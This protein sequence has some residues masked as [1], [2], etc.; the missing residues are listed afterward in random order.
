MNPWFTD[1]EK[2]LNRNELTATSEQK[3]DIYDLLDWLNCAHHS[4]ST[5]ETG[6]E[7]PEY[8]VELNSITRV[9]LSIFKLELSNNRPQLLNKLTKDLFK[10]SIQQ[11]ILR[12]ESIFTDQTSFD[13]LPTLVQNWMLRTGDTSELPWRQLSDFSQRDLRGAQFSS[14]EEVKY[15]FNQSNLSG[16]AFLSFNAQAVNFIDTTIRHA[17][18]R[19]SSMPNAKFTNADLSYT[20]L[21]TI[22]IE[23]ADCC[24]AIFHGTR[25][26]DANLSNANLSHAKLTNVDL[27]YA[28]FKNARLDDAE[29]SIHLS[30][31]SEH[32]FDR[33]INHL[34][35]DGHGVL[36]SIDSIP[37]EYI[38]L[39][40]AAM[41]MVIEQ[42]NKLP[43]EK[44][45]GS[46]TSLADV[47]LRN[48][49]YAED[50]TIAGF[51]DKRLLPRWMEN[52][53][54]ALLNP[55]E[56]D[57]SFVLE[58]LNRALTLDWAAPK[59]Q[60]AVN[61]LL[62]AATQ[63]PDEVEQQLLAN[64]LRQRLLADPILQTALPAIE[65]IEPGLS[66]E[67]YLF[68]AEDGLRV[69]ALESDQ[70]Q[71]LV[72]STSTQVSLQ[73]LYQFERHSSASA[74]DNVAPTD[75]DQTYA[76]SPFLKAQYLSIIGGQVARQLV[77]TVLASS[78]HAQ[79]FIEA[80]QC[81]RVS[82]KLLS[83]L[84]QRELAE[85]FSALWT[86]IE[87]NDGGVH[88]QPAHQEALW[89]AANTLRLDD[90]QTNRARLMLV[91]A[92][93][94]TR[95]SSSALFGS[96]T[97]SPQALRV[98][99]SALLNEVQQLDKALIGPSTLS[100]WQARLMG[101]EFSCTAV[102]SDMMTRHIQQL[103]TPD[104][105]LKQVFLGLYPAAW[106]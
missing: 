25:F 87:G 18:F 72:S 36:T 102:L 67:T 53:N 68:S 80:Q 8:S 66:D 71:K 37:D 2:A 1:V 77:N 35:N 83:P 73:Q 97:D 55:N 74:F 79:R 43:D 100:D 12:R 106:R 3:G 31:S 89:Q 38:P 84:Q 30:L 19:D 10:L 4:L 78:P 16:C 6:K 65:A 81:Q 76:V 29:L 93:M 59:Y 64:Q 88:L 23:H 51:I 11:P 48:P 92:T 57:V 85:H 41:A 39:R 94:F 24:G 61:Q 58:R 14:K 47:L 42:L 91:L 63:S 21:E 5:P 22:N 17:E 26:D 103:A 90:T 69:V 99:A 101:K 34:N 60:G 46:W 44:L 28:N 20:K 27:V 40:T 105:P 33:R 45:Q 82:E 86:G 104:S 52:K 9:L 15:T 95:Y 50:E 70:F 13:K 54:Q 62:Y 32:E 98:Y 7:K 49:A 75:L 96:E 56:V